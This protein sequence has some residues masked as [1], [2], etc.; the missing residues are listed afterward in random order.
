VPLNA[1]QSMILWPMALVWF[2]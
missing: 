1:N 2:R